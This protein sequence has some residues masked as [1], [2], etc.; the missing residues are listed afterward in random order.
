[1]LRPKTFRN[2]KP[3]LIAFYIKASLH[4]IVAIARET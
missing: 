3:H 1:M 4:I 2:V